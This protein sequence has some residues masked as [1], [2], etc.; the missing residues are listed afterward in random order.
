MIHLAQLTYKAINETIEADQ[1]ASFRQWEQKVLPHI[2]DA[3]RGV[4]SP[5]RSH[6]GASL[7]GGKCAR[8]IW[9][10]FRWY[11]M[12]RF[13]GR[14]LRLFNRGHLEEGRVLAMLLMIGCQVYQQDENGK[15]FRISG[16]FGHFGGSGD[17]VVVG[18]PDLPAGMAALLECKTHSNKSFTELTKKGV[19]EAKWE[20]FVQMQTYARKMGLPVSLYFAVNK[21][22]DEIYLELV[23]TESNVGEEY[24][25]RAEGIIRSDKAPPRISN[26]SPGYWLC[27]FCDAQQVCFDRAAAYVSC[28]SCVYGSPALDDSKTWTCSKHNK[29]LTTNDQ[30]AACKDYQAQ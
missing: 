2:G 11:V 20:H 9:Y 23:K 21:D 28:R 1:G 30:L 12:P 15:Q 26:A 16:V 5:F 24:E 4:D 22:T 13:T 3:Y 17:G 18:L 7:I 14:I 10:S 8:A 27:K 25:S 29:A 6:L 19:K